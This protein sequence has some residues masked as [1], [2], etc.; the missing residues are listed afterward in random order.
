MRESA[1]LTERQRTDHQHRSNCLIRGRRLTSMPQGN[2]AE[3]SALHRT[4]LELASEDL[5]PA[6]GGTRRECCRGTRALSHPPAPG[7]VRL[8]RGGEEAREEGK[9]PGVGARRPVGE[10]GHTFSSM[11]TGTTPKNGRMAMP[12]R[13]SAPSSEGRGAMQMPPVSA[14]GKGGRNASGLRG[15]GHGYPG[16]ASGVR[17]GHARV[18]PK[19]AGGS[20]P[21]APERPN[22]PRAPVCSLRNRRAQEEG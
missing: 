5:R 21:G 9:K 13:I 16:R 14:V 19:W 12:G 4:G 6:Q 2:G 18:L 3:L 1:D 22:Q 15:Q 8:G 17:D 7:H 20:P 10:G 11:S